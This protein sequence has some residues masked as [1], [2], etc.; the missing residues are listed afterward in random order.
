L[1]SLHCYRHL[2][3]IDFTGYKVGNNIPEAMTV[4]EDA[5]K[6]QY[7]TTL[8]YS[9]GNET[10]T[11]TFENLPDE[12][13]NF[14]SAK[15]KLIKKGVVPEIPYLDISTW[16]GNYITDSLLSIKGALLILT[17]PYTDKAQ[18]KALEKTGAL[19]QQITAQSDISFI[20][21]SGSGKLMT[22]ATLHPYGIDAPSYFSDAK[23]L[24]TVARANPGLILLY[25]A[26]VVAKW[27]AFDIPSWPTLKNLLDQDWEMV[28]AKFRMMEHLSIE[29]FAVLLT[30]LLAFLHL[31]LKK[32]KHV[33]KRLQPK[34]V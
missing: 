12:S 14:V 23:T 1:L 19:Y 10:K 27:S 7:E 2:P 34:K 13:W 25:D 17:L 30:L 9:K 28:S 26:T 31:F 21:I 5:L 15:T 33:H 6:N 4:P 20:V 22:T 18:I 24:V 8:T 11:F 29:F 16:E 3:L 32:V